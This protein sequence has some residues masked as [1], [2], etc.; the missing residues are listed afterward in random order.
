VK[1][2]WDYIHIHLLVTARFC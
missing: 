1:F 2:N